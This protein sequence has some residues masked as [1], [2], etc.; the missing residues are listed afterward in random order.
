[1]CSLESS[2]AEL[3]VWGLLQDQAVAFVAVIGATQETTS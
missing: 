1:M 3:A 2:V